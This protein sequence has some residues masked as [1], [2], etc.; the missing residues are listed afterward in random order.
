VRWIAAR[1]VEKSQIRDKR[2]QRTG[3]DARGGDMERA[4]RMKTKRQQGAV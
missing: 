3:L 2:I 4:E 1:R